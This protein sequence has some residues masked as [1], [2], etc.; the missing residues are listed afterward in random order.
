MNAHLVVTAA[1]V[2]TPQHAPWQPGCI[3]SGLS[4]IACI[5]HPMPE[6]Q[7]GSCSAASSEA[8]LGLVRSWCSGGGRVRAEG[9]CQQGQAAAAALL[10]SH[11]SA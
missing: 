8:A 1:G 6:G 4:K 10:C 11:A 7:Q 9:K 3:H 5:V 2:H